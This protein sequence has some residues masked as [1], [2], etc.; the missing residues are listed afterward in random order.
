MAT[1]GI[2]GGCH[3]LRSQLSALTGSTATTTPSATDGGGTA[4]SK[5]LQYYKRQ[6][7]ILDHLTTMRREPANPDQGR[8]TLAPRFDWS[9]HGGALG[10]AFGESPAPRH[11]RTGP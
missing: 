4:K 5:I 3:N 9:Q 1:M 7:G 6:P 11:Q 10:G 2:A 8:G